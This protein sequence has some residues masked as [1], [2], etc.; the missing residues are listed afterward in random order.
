MCVA[1]EMSSG[2]AKVEWL[3]G[4]RSVT[5]GVITGSATQQLNKK[6]V[7]SSYLSI[8]LCEWETDK[9]ITCKVTSGGKETSVETNQSQCFE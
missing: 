7:L 3:V 4:G 8:D 2:F 9:R 5:R 6:F 1:S